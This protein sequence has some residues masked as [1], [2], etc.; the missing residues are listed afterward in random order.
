MPHMP[1]IDSDS[2]TTAAGQVLAS[3]HCYASSCGRV[4]LY[5]GDCLDVL[6]LL[7][8]IDLVV[9]DPPYG[10]GKYELDDDAPVVESLKKW[11]RKAVFG[12]PEILCGWCMSLGKPDEWVTW[13][14]TNKAT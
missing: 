3:G 10:T 12:Y 2:P 9:T 1:A 6:P 5:L 13:W 8:G 14:P 11:E 7:S 4:T